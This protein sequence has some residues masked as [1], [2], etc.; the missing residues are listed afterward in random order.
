MEENLR[1]K[2]RLILGGGIRVAGGTPMPFRLSRS[3]AG[4]GA[5]KASVVVSFDGYRIK[6]PITD[7]GEFLLSHNGSRYS[8]FLDGKPFLDEVALEPVVFHAPEQAFFNLDQ[9][10]VFDCAYCATPR[11][12]KSV[13]KDL[14]PAKIVTMLKGAME[15]GN[16]KSFALT[17]GVASS[18]QET[19]DSMVECVKA[20]RESFPDLPIGVEPYVDSA[21]Q[22]DALRSAGA[23]EIKINVEAASEEVFR[24]VCPKKE[25]SL[26]FD[27]LA[28]AVSVFGAGKVAS[29]VIVGMGESDEDV[30]AVVERLASM[31]VCP[32][33][34]PLKVGDAN[35]ESLT[36]V[37]IEPDMDA[38]RLIRL[39]KMQKGAM[40]DH[41]LSSNTFSSMCFECG[42]CDLV[43]FKD[44]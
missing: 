38:D 35:R 25:Y 18:V 34:R 22:I 14:T 40:A 23:D 30:R 42:C 31:G 33:I 29:N 11:L 43:P 19:V 1:K 32:G 8:L 20:V 5:G 13:S 39:A 2:T 27:M 17:S 3:T 28:H 36:A 21:R 41:G 12:G 7:D 24:K 44:F 15:S 4:P 10:C 16:V 37:G 9:R 26:A 6:K